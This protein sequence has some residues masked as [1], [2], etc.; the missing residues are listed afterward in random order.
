MSLEC[1]RS[2]RRG[3]SIQTKPDQ[4]VQTN[5]KQAK[6]QRTKHILRVT[7]HD[8]Q[9]LTTRSAAPYMYILHTPS[10]T[11]MMSSQLEQCVEQRGGNYC[12]VNHHVHIYLLPNQRFLLSLLPSR[13]IFGWVRE[14]VVL[15]QLWCSPRCFHDLLLNALVYLLVSRPPTSRSREEQKKGTTKASLPIIQPNPIAI[16]LTNPPI[17]NH[18][19]QR[20]TVARDGAVVKS[21]LITVRSAWWDDSRGVT[22]TPGHTQLHNGYDV[23]DAHTS[24][25]M[26]DS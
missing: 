6:P 12:K 4:T 10:H 7:S 13:H 24:N 15:L 19:P 22:R 9:H 26:L 3:N 23:V 21:C 1:I 20:S 17:E 16:T 18:Q 11:H 14:F 25:V 8:A 2:R 5:L